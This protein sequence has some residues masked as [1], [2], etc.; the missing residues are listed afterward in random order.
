[1]LRG[2]KCSTRKRRGTGESHGVGQRQI[3]SF[4][5]LDITQT[6][7]HTEGAV[8]TGTK[9]TRIWEEGQKRMIRVKMNQVQ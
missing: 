7:T 5:I 1:M 3:S 4:L 6:H 9:E 2:Q 8:F